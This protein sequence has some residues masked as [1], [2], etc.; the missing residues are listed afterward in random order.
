VDERKEV[1]RRNWACFCLGRTS[2]SA[3]F[4]RVEPTRRF[5]PNKSNTSS[6]LGLLFVHPPTTFFSFK[7]DDITVHVHGMM[8]SLILLRCHA[9]L[10]CRFS[11][12]SIELLPNCCVIMIRVTAKYINPS[13]FVTLGQTHFAKPRKLQWILSSDFKYNREMSP[14]F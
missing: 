3:P 10:M 11:S 4:C 13:R 12:A 9:E 14:V 7:T 2:G 5:F 8:G 6:V 1:Q